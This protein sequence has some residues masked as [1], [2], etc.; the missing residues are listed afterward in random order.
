MTENT[1]LYDVAIVGSGLGSLSAACLLAKEGKKVLVLEQNYLAGGCTSSYWRKGFVFEAGATTLVGLDENMPLHYLLKEIGVNIDAVPLALPMQVHL[2]NGELINKYQPINQWITEAERVF[3]TFQQ[4]KF[5]EFCY[6]IANF[7]WQTSLKQTAFPP[8]KFSDFWHTLKNVSINQLRYGGYSLLSMKQLLKHY[9]L[10]DNQLF[11]AYLNEQLLITA[12]NN[13]AEVNVLFGATALCYTNFGNYYVNGGLINLVNPLVQYLEN[14]DSTVLLRHAVNQIK[15]DND[16]FRLDCT[17]KLQTP[18]TFYAKYLV[19]GIPVNN[20]LEIYK[21]KRMKRLTSPPMV[22]ES[23]K[24]NSAFQMGIGFEPHRSFESLH[25]Q[26]ILPVSMPETESASIFVSLSHAADTS[27]S[28]KAGLQVAS[29]STHLHNPA[30]KS[31]I[32]KKLATDFVFE[33]LE[34]NNLILRKNIAYF[35]ASDALAWEKWTKRKYGFVGGYPQYLHIKPWQMNEA[36]LDGHK[37]YLC[38]DTAYPGQGIPGVVL[39]GIIAAQK[40][41]ADWF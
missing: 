28:D 34:K 14:Q 1:D 27:R 23:D 40:M 17:E 25:H 29:V 4:R 24:L 10:L 35:H 32:D 31:S 39:S 22:L 9:K 6:R 16:T 11:V 30:D 36:R 12:Q 3:G 8:V 33:V 38:G 5:W 15:F 41:K 26:I 37:A 2:P 13:I 18:K 7:V 21:D 19:S 20:L